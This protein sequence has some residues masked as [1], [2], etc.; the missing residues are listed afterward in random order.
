MAKY[1]FINE[2]GQKISAGKAP[3]FWAKKRGLPVLP[4]KEDKPVETKKEVKAEVKEEEKVAEV[5]KP[6]AKRK[7]KST[8]KTD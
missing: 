3:Y 2:S 4:I 8:K 5:K 1:E 7:R 6:R